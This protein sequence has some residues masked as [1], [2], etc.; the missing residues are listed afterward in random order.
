VQFYTFVVKQS[1][2]FILKLESLQQFNC[3]I[4]LLLM[5]SQS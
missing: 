2:F 3:L 5:F 1:D 4:G